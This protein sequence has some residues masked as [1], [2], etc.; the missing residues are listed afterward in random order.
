MSPQNRSLI[1]GLAAPGL[2]WLATS[3]AF[4]Q[5][6][7]P[8]LPGPSAPSPASPGTF[9]ALLLSNGKVVRGEIVEDKAA[10]VYRL[11]QS[12]G[13]V[14]YPRSMVQKAGASVDD[15][16]QYQVA[17]LPAG[18]SEERMKLVRWC[19]TEKLRLQAREQLETLQAMCPNS[20]EIDRMLFNVLASSPDRPPVDEA[21]GRSGFDP[22]N[23]KGQAPAS[24]D[25]RVVGKVQKRFTALPEI[26]DLPQAQAVKRANEFA[27]FVQPVVLQ[28]CARCHNEKYSGSFQLVEI[29][30]KR[31]WNNPDIARSNLDATL[32]LIN[33]D[34]PSRSELLSAGLV[35]HGGS[36]NAIFKGPNDRNYQVL[37]TWA[38]SLRPGRTV[39]KAG[40]DGVIRT[41]LN[42][43]DGAAPESFASDRA[44]RPTPI[45]SP[46]ASLPPAAGSTGT[47]KLAG[48]DYNAQ[49]AAA[50]AM[51]ATPRTIVDSYEESAEFVNGPGERPQFPT[52]YSVG[53]AKIPPRP[54]PAPSS[55]AKPPDGRSRPRGRSTGCLG[56]DRHP[57]RPEHGHGRIG[58]ATPTSCPAWT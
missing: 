6:S 15:L 41:G 18:D 7:P 36:K 40:G 2:L 52:P 17:R 29:K 49:A 30:V 47:P 12:G 34:D 56:P 9:Q 38:K 31:D 14:S 50:A 27:E 32:R 11:R 21:L 55:K 42:S 3:V 58:A 8:P 37:A 53:G 5:D 19:L 33:S 10:G 24:L 46:S 20:P 23:S 39:S 22:S 4:G 44:N 1:V 13:P 57:G 43:P 26:F 35:P 51:G 16:Y 45:P 54:K 28:S 48:F 25:P